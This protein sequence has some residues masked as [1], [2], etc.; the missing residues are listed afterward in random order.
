MEF[1]KFPP[2]VT[3]WNVEDIPVSEGDVPGLSV[4]FAAWDVSPPRPFDGVSMRRNGF[5]ISEAE[6]KRL[7]TAARTRKQDHG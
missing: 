5:V 1:P 7:W 6:F 3:F 2:S 4:E